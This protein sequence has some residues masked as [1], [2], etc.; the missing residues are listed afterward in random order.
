MDW[1]RKLNEAQL[2]YS[3]MEKELLAIVY[4]LIEFRTMLWGARLT[5][6]TDHKNLTFRTLNTQ[7]ALWWRLFLEDFHPMFKYFPGKDN[8]LADCFSRLLRMVKPSEGKRT[9]KGKLIAFDKLTLPPIEQEIMHFKDGLCAALMESEI[10]E[11]M[12]CRFACC[13]EDNEI[14]N[15]KEMF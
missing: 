4:C 8:V 3:T 1:S 5:V 10:Q 2:N 11:T 7:R 6:F 14:T 13:R 15:E 9:H 12:P